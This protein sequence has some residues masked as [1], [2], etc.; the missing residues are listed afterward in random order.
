MESVNS[1]VYFR[2]SSSLLHPLP[3]AETTPDR[4]N[5]LY[6]RQKN[7]GITFLFIPELI[8]SAAMPRLSGTGCGLMN[9]RRTARCGFVNSRRTARCGFV[10]DH[11]AA[12]CGFVND[13]CTRRGTVMNHDRT[14]R[15][16]VVNDHRTARSVMMIFND[17]A[18]QSQ[19][20]QCQSGAF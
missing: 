13:H 1:K 7:S 2:R 20:K 9:S 10:N 16:R 4:L 12:R 3:A 5:F 15:R 19:S 14:A 17:T 8:F 18:R 6:S 11:R